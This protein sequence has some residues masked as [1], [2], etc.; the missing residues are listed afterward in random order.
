MAIKQLFIALFAGVV[1][2]TGCTMGKK[3]SFDGS[4]YP[5]YSGTDLGVTYTPQK[6]IFKVWAPTASSVKLRLYSQGLGGVAHSEIEMEL[7]SNGV[8]EWELEGDQKGVYYTY[9]ATVDGKLMNE[10]TDPYAR[11]A[12]A[13]G[14]RGMVI[15][16]AACNPEGWN[17]DKRPE[18]KSF[19]DIIIWE[20]HM[21]D[22]SVHSSSGIVN[23]GKFLGLTELGTTSPKGEKTGLDHIKELGVTHVHLL[24]VFDFRTIDE[25]KLDV[26]QFNWGYDP[27]N[28]NVPEGSYSTNPYDGN[29]R[30]KEFKEMVKAL[31]ANGIRVIMDVVY[32]HTS[33]T[34]VT[35]FEQLVPGYY[36]RTDSLGRFSDAA[37]CGNETASERYMFR[38][39]MVESVKYWAQE[40]HVDG[41][42]FDLM[43]IH[44]IETMNLIRKELSDVD[45]TIFIYGEGWMAS[46]TPLADSKQARKEH[47][48]K[49]NDIAVFSDELRDGLRGRWMNSGEEGFMC[50]N[51]I[52]SESVKY[53]IVGGVKHPQIN[54]SEVIYAGKSY[55]EKP[56]Q[57][58]SY[59]SC[60][61]NP[62]LWD[63]ISESCG[64]LPESER[65]KIQKLANGVVL[66]TQG[67]P[68]LQAGEEIVRTKQKV[69]NSYN[70]PDSINNIDWSRKS[71]YKE[72]F[73]YYRDMIS[74]RKNHPAFRMTSADEIVKNL[75]FLPVKSPSVVAYQ[76]GNHANGDVWSDIVVV[77]NGGST[78]A[79]FELP[80]GKW[81]L[82]ANGAGALE[83]GM[84]NVR[85]SGTIGAP[86]RTLLVLRRIE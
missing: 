58:I 80:S 56:T 29:V 36:Y 70:A 20:L 45:P 77:I 72:V 12:G 86:A 26:P 8:W 50:G 71:T 2:F 68:F 42:R 62:C 73:N 30:V 5:E 48:Y 21:R 52:L 76:I 32:N 65:I 38:K 81:S 41:F 64:K 40:Y 3:N 9:Q 23:K 61:D 27:L 37:A 25:T 51:P 31:H 63:K 49:L 55:V 85:Y 10:V 74:L 66:T 75:S 84:D 34:T 35:P 19:G 79:G 11:T 39:F 24:P 15:D 18:L 54:Y 7:E 14:L 13:N 43:A 47:I 22:L 60:H 44:D 53:G 82:V 83:E 16:L 78:D 6:S 57:F 4:K 33:G 1:L 17:E 59:V 67:V 28:Y 46:K 69:E